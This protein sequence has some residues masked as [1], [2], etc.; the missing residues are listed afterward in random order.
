M[1]VT[2]RNTLSMWRSGA[3]SIRRRWIIPWL[4][5]LLYPRAEAIVGVSQG[6]AD[7]L[8]AF[9]GLDADRV[10]SIPNPVVDDRL[11][12]LADEPLDPAW[13]ARLEGRRVVLNAGR[14]VPQKDH[15]MLLEAFA[16][17]HRAQ[18]DTCS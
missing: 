14:F 11:A 13:Q 9:V 10:L 8:A 12:R 18:P 4:V 3:R 5:R 6:V 15:G 16:E 2:E 7:D 1:V 17:V